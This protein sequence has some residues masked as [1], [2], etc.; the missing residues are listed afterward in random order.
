MKS[1]RKFAPLFLLAALAGCAANPH[2]HDGS[3]VYL[4]APATRGRN[5]EGTSTTRAPSSSARARIS[6]AARKPSDSHAS[7]RISSPR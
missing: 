4:D 3:M 5:V 1:M 6:A 7:P 2:R